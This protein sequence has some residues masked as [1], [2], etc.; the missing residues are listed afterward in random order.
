M[1]RERVKGQAVERQVA[2]EQMGWSHVRDERPEGS[3]ITM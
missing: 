2:A 3:R 1:A